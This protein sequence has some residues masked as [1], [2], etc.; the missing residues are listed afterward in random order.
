MKCLYSVSN[1]V[2]SYREN[3]PLHMLE[4]FGCIP[5]RF[6]HRC[7]FARQKRRFVLPLPAIALANA[8]TSPVGVRFARPAEIA[9]VFEFSQAI[10]LHLLA[11]ASKIGMQNP[12]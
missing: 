3:I 10:T 11:N 2:L 4:R 1:A 7:A 9:G 6:L 5:R 8:V 12:S